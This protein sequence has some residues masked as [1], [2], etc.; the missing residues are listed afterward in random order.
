ME[1]VLHALMTISRL[2]RQRIAG[3][4]VDAGT[5]WLLKA[6]SAH[7]WLRV[8]EL[9]ALANLDA[10]TVSR[11]VAQLHRSGLIERSQDPADGRAQRVAISSAG[12]ELLLEGL[13]RRQAVLSRSLDGWDTSDI[14]TL[15]E[16][17]TRLAGGIENDTELE[18]A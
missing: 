2:L 10:S 17:L 6:L 4:H 3:D 11:H 9:A 14:E 13:A 5:F 7:E 12:R 16:L 15:G 18:R 8:T 1:S